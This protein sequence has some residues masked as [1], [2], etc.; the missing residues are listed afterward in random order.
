MKARLTRALRRRLGIVVAAGAVVVACNEDFVTG[1][2]QP[3]VTI[4]LRNWSDTLVLGDRRPV[5]IVVLDSKGREIVGARVRL[6]LSAPTVLGADVSSVAT[7]GTVN[8][9]PQRTGIT[10][11]SLALDDPRF[12]PATKLVRGTVVTAGVRLIS[13][14]DTT[15]TSVGDTSL[16]LASALGRSDASAS[17]TLFPIAG[18]G[19]SWTRLGGGAPT[20][21]GTGDSLRTVS[22]AAGIDTLVVSH[23]FC[24]RGARCADTLVV[25]LSQ[26]PVSFTM[27]TDTLWAWSLGDTVVSRVPIVDARGN[28]IAGVSVTAAPLTAADSAIVGVSTAAGVPAFERG[29]AIQAGAL[30]AVFGSAA[31]GGVSS[32]ALVAQASGISHVALRALAEDG[33]VLGTSQIV[34]VVRQIAKSVR[35]APAE[36][37]VTPGDSIPVLLQAR[38]ARGHLILDA[39]FSSTMSAG[40]YRAGRILVSATAAP[41]TDFLH[42]TVT[43]VAAP[44]SHPRAQI[45]DPAPDSAK[46]IVRALPRIAAG[47]TASATGNLLSTIVL[48]ADHRPL[49][50]VWVRFFVPAGSLA[51]ADS[52]LSDANG[53]VQTRWLLPTTAGRYTATA[54]VLGVGARADSAGDIVLRRTTTVIAG[55][56]TALVVVSQSGATATLGATLGAPIVVQLVDAFGNASSQAGVPVTVSANGGSGFTLGGTLTVLTDSLGQARFTDLAGSGTAGVQ[57]LCF[58]A[59]AGSATLGAS[60]NPITFTGSSVTPPALSLANSTIAASPTTVVADGASTS[61]ITLTLRDVLGGLYTQSGGTLLLASNIGTLLP[62]V[63]NG[64][65]TYTAQLRAPTA[66]GIATISGTVGGSP[67]GSTAQV[68]F[69]AGAVSPAQTTISVASSTV[70]GGTSPVIVT[71]RDA[72]GNPVTG[73][74]AS[75]SLSATL[76]TLGTLVDNGDGTYTAVLTAGGATGTA[77]VSA[78]VGG[79]TFGAT[80]PVTA[81]SASLT[82]STISAS[83]TSVIV[84]G[85]SLITVQLRDAGGNAL[86]SGGGTVTLGAS[87]GSLGVVTDNLD[88]TYSAVLTVPTTPGTVTVSGTLGG[89]AIVSTATVA[90]SVGAPSSTASTLTAT[91]TS[92]NQGDATTVTMVIRD[93]FANVVTGAVA[94]DVVLAT[95]LGTLGSVSCGSGICTATYTA[96]TGGSASITAKIGGTNIGGSP[97]AVTIIATPVVASLSQ[98]TIAASPASVTADGTSWS[99]ITVQLRDAGG[100]ALTAS[101]GIVTL[102][103]S[104]GTLSSVTD[105]LDGTYTAKL[106]APTLTGA[107]SVTA[108]LDGNALTHASNPAIVTFVA[109]V[110]S[111]TTSTLAA[112]STSLATN[113]TT[114]VTVVVKDAQGNVVT[115]A[116]ASDVTLTSTIGTLGVTSC[117]GGTCTAT[118]TATTAGAASISATIGGTSIVNSPVAV[119]ISSVFTTVQAIAS[120]LLDASTA[121]TPFAPVTA[122]GGTAPYAFALSGGTLPSGMSFDTST[123]V[124]SGTATAPLSSTSFTVTVTDAA[125]AASSKTFVL[126]VSPAL[127]TTQAVPSTTLS[128]GTPYSSFAPVTASGGSA[129]LSFAL[130]GG[131]LPAGASFDTSTG[132]ISGTATAS[133]SQTTFTVTVTDAIGTVSSRTFDLTVNG[134]PS[135]PAITGIT[136]GDTQLSVAFTAPASDGGAAITNYEYSTNDGATW[137]LRSPA[138]TVSPIVITGLT[139]GTTYQVRLRAVNASG[140]GVQSAPLASTPMTTASAPAIT[141]VTAGDTQLSVAFTAPASNGGSAITNYEYS[142]DGGTNWTTGSPAATTSPLVITGLTNGTTYQVKLRAV[143]AAGSGA[144]SSPS[145]GMPLTVPGAP[146]SLVAIGGSTNAAL[147]WTAPASNGGSAITDYAVQYSSNGGGSWSTFAHAASTTAAIT[148]TG[149]TN[150]TAYQFRV[151]AVNVAGTGATSATVAATPGTPGAPTGVTI[152]FNQTSASTLDGLFSWTA[153]ASNGGSAITDY[154]IEYKTSAAVSWTTFVHAAS[155]TTSATVPGLAPTTTYEVRI[156]AKN[157][158]GVG[159]PSA[160]ASATTNGPSSRL[161]CFQPGNSNSSANSITIAPC[162]GTVT[163]N[164]ILIPVTIANSSTTTPV[165]IN[166][167]ANTS[168]FTAL[169]TQLNGGNQTTI[170]Y[171]IADAS[172]VGRVTNY[173]FTWTGNVKNAITLVT[174]KTTDGNAPNY[175][176][177]N[178][179]GTV[180]TAPAVTVSDVNS[181]TLVYIYTMVGVALSST[182][183]SIAEWSVH[184]ELWKNT[185]AGA[186]NALAAAITT[187]DVDKFATGTT[188]GRDATTSSMT[189]TTKWNAAVLVLKAP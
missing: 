168:G 86:A 133:Q 94:S 25:R 123:G 137:T 75:I 71:L 150:G 170:F 147:T 172:D 145:S 33:R 176:S 27:P 149:L 38:D 166:E 88:G 22:R 178:G 117:V 35:V 20:P 161:Q 81:S 112:G 41:G 65:G 159:A 127:V 56:P 143:T 156:S 130:T 61:T 122:G 29:T 177:A 128:V 113:Q 47:D 110:P 78:T 129:P 91:S 13:A 4:A 111:A 11:I 10:D 188:P 24:L 82:T 180:A 59:T 167:D 66:V 189:S 51:G 153:P 37:D 105:N 6:T 132:E 179:I 74:G 155:T 14:R 140:S 72:F 135:E 138:S 64:N 16:V 19:V 7:G 17:A 125:L 40:A 58:A 42:A 30:R 99:T 174:Y 141:S 83:P 134:P 154:V 151:A 124:I 44:S 84:G 120:T 109:G 36:A 53:V 160:I 187:E 23:A 115:T 108:S 57:V 1:P 136:A 144:A 73:A 69:V 152:T 142:T 34:V 26:V 146:T 76:G 3:A 131:T 148:V 89:S 114:T 77:S 79:Q 119:S 95:T 62:A 107:A 164:V 118:Y 104:S 8:L 116:T 63:D 165:A 162:A 184:S 181:Y 21:L 54:F 12:D 96:T 126:A 48:G 15:V 169:G 185:T 31:T 175:L 171:K 2:G 97:T 101:G 103:T 5:G 139:N 45:A 68:T 163:G 106:V 85:S 93:A 80:L 92:L 18:Q 50:G 70:V 158:A 28:A 100:V 121:Y 39:S 173:G 60:A 102:S 43:G 157:S 186:N 182:T 55:A 98:S 87:T 32:P 90:V 46:V 67:V 183:P 49:V 52:V 9:S